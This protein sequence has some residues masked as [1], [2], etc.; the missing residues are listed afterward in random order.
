MLLNFSANIL[1]GTRFFCLEKAIIRYFFSIFYLLFLTFCPCTQQSLPGELTVCFI[2]MG[3]TASE[4]GF[5]QWKGR[6]SEQI[7]NHCKS[8]QTLFSLCGK[9]ASVK[10]VLMEEI[11]QRAVLAVSPHPWLWELGMAGA[12]AAWTEFWQQDQAHNGKSLLVLVLYKWNP[13]FVATNLEGFPLTTLLRNC[14]QLS[15]PE[16][17]SMQPSFEA[18]SSLAFGL[19]VKKEFLSSVCVLRHSCHTGLAA[20]FREITFQG[21]YC[22]LYCFKVPDSWPVDSFIAFCELRVWG[23]MLLLFHG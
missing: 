15:H 22:C 8:K 20:E 2:T 6:E 16:P 11:F 10:N 9:S 3:A 1:L 17:S 12:A 7:M 18:F 19:P 13:L 5:I 23:R 14:F 21:F 4:L